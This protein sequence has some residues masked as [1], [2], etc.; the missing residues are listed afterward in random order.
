MQTPSICVLSFPEL[1]APGG[2]WAGGLS[3]LFINEDGSLIRGL[4]YHCLGSVV[5]DALVLPVP[6]MQYDAPATSDAHCAWCCLKCLS[7]L[8]PPRLSKASI[9]GTSVV[10]A[11]PCSA[12]V[13]LWDPWA[14]GGAGGDPL[15]GG[16]LCLLLAGDLSIFQKFK[17]PRKPH[18]NCKWPCAALAQER[19]IHGELR[20]PAMPEH[21]GIPGTAGNL[22]VFAEKIF[23]VGPC[24]AFSL[25]PL[26]PWGAG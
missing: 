23:R 26:A 6:R 7:F 15:L 10:S 2:V 20:S 9:S 13:L 25:G 19:D 5:P 14:A 22:L 21:Q 16:S 18:P 3:G 8:S 11:F 24:L 4:V 12:S 17:A 1:C